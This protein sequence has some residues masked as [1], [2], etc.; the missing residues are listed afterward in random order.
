MMNDIK[1][2]FKNICTTS[3]AIPSLFDPRFNS[4]NVCITI[5]CQIKPDITGEP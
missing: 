5:V 2:P 4:D 3:H 1:I